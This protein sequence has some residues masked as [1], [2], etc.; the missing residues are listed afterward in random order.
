MDNGF[1]S[2]YDNQVTV[3][4]KIL[5][6]IVVEKEF[7]TFQRAGRLIRLKEVASQVA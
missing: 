3:L 2:C 5:K 4:I 7:Q 1:V 6:M